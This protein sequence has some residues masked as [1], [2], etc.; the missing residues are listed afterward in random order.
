LAYSAS[1]RNSWC[2]KVADSR[3]RGNER[4]DVLILGENS[5]LTKKE[6]EI[7]IALGDPESNDHS[8]KHIAWLLGITEGTTKEYLS[9]LKK[10]CGWDRAMCVIMGYQMWLEKYGD[11]R[12]KAKIER[13]RTGGPSTFSHESVTPPAAQGLF[14]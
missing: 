6:I 5:G 8:N 12:Q 1:S 14:I 4:G 13:F 9:H 11:D 7:L 3:K 10:K 2:D